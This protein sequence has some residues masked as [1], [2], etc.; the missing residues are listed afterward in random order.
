MATADSSLGDL[1][2]TLSFLAFSEEQLLATV[3]TTHT[4]RERERERERTKTKT[5]Q[6]N[7][8]Y[9]KK[10]EKAKHQPKLDVGMRVKARKYFEF[11]YGIVN[12][13]CFALFES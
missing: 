7:K 9:K 13:P 11:S 1:A 10:K 12:H 6:D 8:N 3:R 2:Q 5:K 4:E